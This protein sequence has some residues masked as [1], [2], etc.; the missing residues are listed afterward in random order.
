MSKKMEFIVDKKPYDGT[1][2]LRRV[3][4]EKFIQWYIKT[5]N[6][7]LSAINAGY[8]QHTA[9]VK[10]SQIKNR[11]D[12]QLRYS[13]LLTKLASDKLWCKEKILEKIQVEA[14]SVHSKPFERI[15][16][17]ELLGRSKALFQDK[18]RISGKIEGIQPANVFVID[19]AT[20]SELKKITS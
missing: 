20:A 16:A 10:G 9:A 14:E 2:A 5:N 11:D 7:T 18:M 8:P 15:K 19:N 4:F 13:Y 6:V 1:T 17:L 3:K 12:V